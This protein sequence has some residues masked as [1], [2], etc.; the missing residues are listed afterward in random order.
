M[1]RILRHE[2]FPKTDFTIREKKIKLIHRYNS[3][4]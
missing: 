2:A 1:P 4:S 3:I